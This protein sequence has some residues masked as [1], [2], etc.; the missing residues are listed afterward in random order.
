MKKMIRPIV[1]SLLLNFFLTLSLLGQNAG[2]RAIGPNDIYRMSTVSNPK[3]SPE[4]Q[5]VLD[6]KS[7]R[8]NSSH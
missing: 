1:L 8:L 3:I 7:T 2:L 4:G 5:W 6:R